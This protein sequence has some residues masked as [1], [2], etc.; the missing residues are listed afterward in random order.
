LAQQCFRV[1]GRIE[2]GHDGSIQDRQTVAEGLFNDRVV[3][4]L[5]QTVQVWGEHAGSRAVA[6]VDNLVGF[7]HGDQFSVHAAVGE[8]AP[9]HKHIAAAYPD[10]VGAVQGAAHFRAAEVHLVGIES[11]FT[12]ISEFAVYARRAHIDRRG[13]ERIS[14]HGNPSTSACKLPQPLGVITKTE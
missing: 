4:D 6:R 3:V 5:F 12:E 7:D 2:V 10:D 14:D 8:S 11:K 1:T 13:V 9:E